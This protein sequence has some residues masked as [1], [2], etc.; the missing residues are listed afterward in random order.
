MRCSP[1][2]K[3]IGARGIAG[4]IV[5]ML[6][7]PCW[8]QSGLRQSLE[9]LDRN[10]DGEIEPHEITPLARP[11][12][13]RI[14]SAKRMSLDKANR[15]DELQEAARIYHAFQNGVAGKDV[16]PERTSAVRP[17]GVM[18]EQAVVPEFGVGELKYPY[19]P[20]DLR[21]AE[22]TLRQHDNDGNGFIDRREA[23]R[24]QWR[25]RD[26]FDDDLNRDD[27]LERLELA[28][29]YARRRLLADDAGEL[30][31][32][33]RRTGNGIEPS[34]KSSARD[35]DDSRWWRRGGSSTWLSASILG[36]FDAN[37]NGRLEANETIGMQ[38]PVTQIDVDADGELSRDEL[39]AYLM[40]VQ[41]QSG[42]L[43]DGI[44]AWFYEN[45]IDRD[46]QIT[47]AEFTPEL[48][49]DRVR[50]FE[51]LDLNGDGLLIARELVQSK[52]NMGGSFASEAAEPLPPGRTIIS[53]IEVT[54][55]LWVGRLRVEV[56]ITHSHTG[57]LDAYLTAPDG[58]R[59]ELFTEV[60]G[61]DDN[62]QGTIFDD[63]AREPITKAKPPFEG[64]FLPEAVLNRQP[65]LNQFQGMNLKGVWQLIIRGTRSD[66]FGMLH[67]W[68]LL[69]EP[70]ER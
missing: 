36:R 44:P 18:R 65:G 12:L 25:Y 3:M 51:T 45:D 57:Y 55:D 27:R 56:S 49:P 28:Q 59:V 24:A 37:R 21:E 66:R 15:I 6:T 19:T 48:L 63:S 50:E 33:V 34:P 17:F 2:V 41:R 26:P 14:T 7:V 35:G 8:G 32:R 69:V 68:S 13:E 31:Q 43:D 20:E 58:R 9:R 16:E 29:R 11:Y 4:L 53:E 61:H 54:D 64:S 1:I 40:D 5:A 67:R 38:L 23:A 22:Q 46:S 70:Q 42:G 47:L 10:G 52:A 39:Q 30:L 62:F 60:G